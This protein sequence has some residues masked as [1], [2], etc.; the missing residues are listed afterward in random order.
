M[1]RYKAL[2]KKDNRGAAMVIVLCILAVLMALIASLLTVASGTI[3][4]ARNRA[5]DERY[6]VM[7]STLS[8]E[9]EKQLS[10]QQIANAIAPE[11]ALAEWESTVNPESSLQAYVRM[12]IS[13][14]G[15]T[16]LRDGN[17]NSA[18]WPCYDD[19]LASSVSDRNIK[20]F[21]LTGSQLTEESGGNYDVQ[22]QIYWATTSDEL[23]ESLETMETT[24]RNHGFAY[25]EQDLSLIVEVSCGF[26]GRMQRVTTSY[27]L[28]PMPPT[29]LQPIWYWT[30]GDA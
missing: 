7:A 4:S 5:M 9:L 6:L 24:G 22:V 19:S 11:F 29:D 27:T 12:K 1:Y 21:E 23:R 17:L 26:E 8:Q 28:D 14:C 30:K 16:L 15:E 20:I 18:D 3:G 10:D 2:R 13:Q 25:A